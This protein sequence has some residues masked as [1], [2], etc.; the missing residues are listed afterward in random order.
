MGLGIEKPVVGLAISI[1]LILVALAVCQGLLVVGLIGALMRFRR[2]LPDNRDCPKAAIVL[3]LRG[4]D[5][6]LEECL[7]SLLKQDYPDYRLHIVVDN[8][9]DPAR[10]VADSL[11]ERYGAGR[12]GVEILDQRHGTCSLKCSAVVQ[13]IERLDE[14]VR[15]TALVDADTA[16]PPSWLRE[17]VAPLA[18]DCVGAATGNRWYMPAVGSWGALVRY[19][20]NA[21]AIVQMYW[22]EVPWGGTLA[23]KNKAI[24]ELDLLGRWRQ[25]FCEDTML[26]RQLGRRGLRVK[27]VPSLMMVNRE[28][29]GLRA[30]GAWIG[31][32]L[33]TMRLYHPLWPLVL[34]HGFGTT[35]LLIAAVVVTAI[36]ALHHD[37]PAALW[38]GGGLAVYELIM[39][40]LLAPL[41]IAVR[42]IVRSQ[43]GPTRWLS[44]KTILRLIPAIVLTQAVYTLALIGAQ[45]ARK[46]SWRGVCY[47]IDGPWSIHRLDDSPYSSDLACGADGHSL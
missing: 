12:V 26:Y 6:F 34:L 25:A 33:L 9:Q 31:R 16:P 23:V 32:Q 29:C 38:C 18:D 4:R 10:Q 20:W 44:P 21:A 36:A 11:A 14:S 43:G 41:E 1:A 46:A 22:Y 3:C 27:F 7:E 19:L 42:R 2:G 45:F 35:L 28:D 30:C 47:R 40:G 15:V 8:R 37:W 17:L 13:A 39:V 5:P 24:N